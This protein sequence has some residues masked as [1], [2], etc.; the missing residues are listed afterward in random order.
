V[1]A[2]LVEAVPII[3]VYGMSGTGKSSLLN[4][5]LVPRLRQNEHISVMTV[6][7]PT[8]DVAS[9]I[10]KHPG[11]AQPFP[12]DA[13]LR[14]I[15]E[16]QAEAGSSRL[17]I[18]I[19]QFEERLKRDARLSELFDDLAWLANSRTR[20]TA[21]VLSIREDYLPEL[22]PLMRR[23]PGLLDAG[24]RVPFLRR[25]A[26]VEAVRGPVAKADVSVKV[27][28]SLIELVLTDLEA[29]ARPLSSDSATPIEPGYFQIVWSKLW[30]I[31][32]EQ[33]GGHELQ[34][35]TYRR[36]NDA[37]GIVGSFVKESIEKSLPFERE[38]LYASIRYLVL[39]TG[40]KIAL[41]T[42]DLVGLIRRDDFSSPEVAWLLQERAQVQVYMSSLFAQLTR[43]ATP[44][45]RRVFRSG[46]EEFELVHD[47]LGLILLEWRRDYARYR[48][49]EDPHGSDLDLLEGLR[50]GRY[51]RRNVIVSAIGVKEPLA[52]GVLEAFSRVSTLATSSTSVAVGPAMSQ[53]SAALSKL[54]EWASGPPVKS[55]E[56][57]RISEA[58]SGCVDEL[59]EALARDEDVHPEE[60]SRTERQAALL[61]LVR[62][63]PLVLQQISLV[64]RD[65]NLRVASPLSRWWQLPLI[66]LLLFVAFWLSNVL[67]TWVFDVPDVSYVAVTFAVAGLF[68]VLLMFFNAERGLTRAL[69]PIT[70]DDR[71]PAVVALLMAWPLNV[72][73]VVTCSYF[74]SAVADWVGVAPTVG[75]NLAALASS[76]AVAFAYGW[77]LDE[78]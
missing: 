78:L 70:S 44:L 38:L 23:V 36:Q 5:G 26:L 12:D 62:I 43:S 35:L 4:A 32:I 56:A 77:A 3:I 9:T 40:A 16:A 75:F 65:Y 30:A 46:R 47:L 39:P 45:F 19:D 63:Q 41:T 33:S 61:E 22:E 31:D 20:G 53:L 13:D 15:A 76:V 72:V 25:E 11:M 10:R 60:G 21:A 1:L 73:A 18:I 69:W 8:Q 49:F 57:A 37:R 29:E 48:S 6:S 28:E 64:E 67:I 71:G 59:I 14:R 52:P 74:G 17:V 42:D 7:D 58:A 24:Y 51:A 54:N 50:A 2:N 55:E 66:A 68:G 34:E 27:A